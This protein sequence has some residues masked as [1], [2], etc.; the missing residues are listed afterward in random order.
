MLD[1]HQLLLSP[2]S[3]FLSSHSRIGIGIF[4]FAYRMG[5]HVRIASHLVVASPDTCEL[6]FSIL[7]GRLAVCTYPSP[8]FHSPTRISRISPSLCLFNLSLLIVVLLTHVRCSH[9]IPPSHTH[10]PTYSGLIAIP[11]AIQYT[12]PAGLQ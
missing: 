8:P 2:S 10:I 7:L 6:Y 5:I 4:A 1:G 9:H 3:P 12:M 11:L